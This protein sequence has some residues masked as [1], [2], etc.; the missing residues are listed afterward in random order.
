MS[1]CEYYQELISRLVDD[2]LSAEEQAVLVSHL[3]HCPDC[4]TL[5]Q[6]F[7]SISGVIAED[8]AE[9]PE[10]LSENVMA[11]LR[12]EAIK[13]ENRKKRRWKGPLATAACLAVV[14]AAAWLMPNMFRA[15]SAAPAEM[16]AAAS[17]YA[18]PQ[19]PEYAL[20]A[21]GIDSGSAEAG[22]APEEAD[23]E[24]AP[25]EAAEAYSMEEEAA[26][27]ME[28]APSAQVY[29]TGASRT[30]GGEYIALDGDRAATFA[31]LLSGSEAPLP[32][33]EADA[34][35]IVSYEVQDV[36][37]CVSLCVFGE[38]VYYSFDNALFTLSS[39]S[40]SEFFA[41]IFPEVP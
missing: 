22:A 29:A 21:E 2:E 16:S 13:T 20:P 11:E 27:E 3:E 33:R 8:L 9:P 35:Y 15:D 19:A 1:S 6:A 41:L 30:S 17:D 24:T 25:A 14:I 37:Y 32:E 12:R 4:A 40:K 36:E 18:A 5:V 39:S 10:A 28:E 7:Q 31:V 23:L 38:Q 34:V 26:A